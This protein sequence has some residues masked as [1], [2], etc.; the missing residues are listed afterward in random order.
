MGKDL[1]KLFPGHFKL[2]IGDSTKT[3][4]VWIE[5]GVKCDIVSVDGGHEYPTV[6]QDLHNMVKA[7]AKEHIIVSNFVFKSRSKI[8][9]SRN[10]LYK[11]AY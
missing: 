1:D 2:T 9:V 11:Y 4:P 10:H 6:I 7:A 5:E 8:P 3:V